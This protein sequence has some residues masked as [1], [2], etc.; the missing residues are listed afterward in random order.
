MQS[1]DRA[2]GSPLQIRVIDARAEAL[3]GYP[4]LHGRTVA[5]TAVSRE[6]APR[7]RVP[8]ESQS[9]PAGIRAEECLLSPP[10]RLSGMTSLAA[11]GCNRSAPPGGTP[12]GQLH[13]ATELGQPLQHLV[14]F[15]R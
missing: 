14:T 5:G 10:R 13:Q 11:V 9:S 7:R 15:G 1:C 12:I 2:I 6:C 8:S 3:L 4:T